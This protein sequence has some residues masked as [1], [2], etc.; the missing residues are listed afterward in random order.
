VREYTPREL[1][2]CVRA[3]GFDVDSL[4]TERLPGVDESAWVRTLLEEHGFD[5]SLR[6]EQTYCL[7]KKSGVDRQTERYPDFL[8]AK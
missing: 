5:T 8:Y 4:F 7:A 2:D 6:G 3:A 1:A